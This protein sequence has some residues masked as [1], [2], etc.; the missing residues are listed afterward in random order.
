MLETDQI[1]EIFFNFS[2][3]YIDSESVLK[4]WVDEFLLMEMYT[5]LVL[6]IALEK[7]NTLPTYVTQ[8]LDGDI[9]DLIKTPTAHSQ[10]ALNQYWINR[11]VNVLQGYTACPI[12][13]SKDARV[14]SVKKDLLSP[15]GHKVLRILKHAVETK[16]TTDMLGNLAQSAAQKANL[17]LD[18]FIDIDLSN[19]FKKGEYWPLLYNQIE[20]SM[21]TGCYN[22]C[23]HCGFDAKAP[24]SHMPYPIFLKLFKQHADSNRIFGGCDLYNDSDPLSYR[25]P[26]IN[27]DAGDVVLALPRFMQKRPFNVSFLTKGV[28]TKQDEITFARVVHHHS[29]WP[30]SIILGIELSYIDLP[31]EPAAHNLKRIKRTAQIH[32]EII[33]KN[34]R[35]RHYHLPNTPTITEAELGLPAPHPDDWYHVIES[36]TQIQ[37][38]GRWATAVQHLSPSDKKALEQTKEDQFTSN[39]YAISSNLTLYEVRLQGDKFVRRPMGSVLDKKFMNG[40]KIPQPSF[41]SDKQRE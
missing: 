41:A 2:K 13:L 38:V 1:K 28:L 32:R 25:D 11:A 40:L 34:P 9:V 24:V 10:T 39:H 3:K 16:R 15:K 29:R 31:N 22:H 23:V 8:S 37:Q 36:H 17:D 6:K 5:P 21:S 30:T 18:L 20:I 4:L 14:N 7:W 27:A 19:L 26:I 33:N 35:I 12:P